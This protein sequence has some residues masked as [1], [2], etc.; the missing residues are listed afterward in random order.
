MF[1]LRLRKQH[2]LIHA[3]PILVG[4][5][6]LGIA[7]LVS[8]PTT[9]SMSVKDDHLATLKAQYLKYKAREQGIDSQIQSLLMLRATMSG[10]ADEKLTELKK[11]GKAYCKDKD[12]NPEEQNE[13][14]EAGSCSSAIS[15]PKTEPAPVEP[16]KPA[17]PSVKH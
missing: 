11:G 10:A 13:S 7:Q 9:N 17:A 8:P 4:C 5:T 15:P 12:F 16:L 3:I 6:L 14:S 1:E 2:S